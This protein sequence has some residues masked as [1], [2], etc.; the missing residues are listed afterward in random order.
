MTGSG[1]CLIVPV[2]PKGKAGFSPHPPPERWAQQMP[3]L[4][5]YSQRCPLFSVES[6]FVPSQGVLRHIM[7]LASPSPALVSAYQS[8]YPR[9]SGNIQVSVPR[10]LPPIQFGSSSESS[11]EKGF[12][13]TTKSWLKFL[14]PTTLAAG[15]LY[16]NANIV[17][18]LWGL[19]STMSKF[20]ADNTKKTLSSSQRLWN[21]TKSFC[22]TAAATLPGLYFFTK[23][24]HKN[25]LS[26]MGRI[27]NLS[28]HYPTYDRRLADLGT[29]HYVGLA[30]Q[31]SQNLGHW[32][33]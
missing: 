31:R 30:K 13:E 25:L 14:L 28:D 17:K 8:A 29:N 6:V 2:R 26:V 4:R 3:P 16:Q 24:I 22:F 15:A 23:D 12:L 11:E 19:D 20:I 33:F 10:S 9:L 1:I 7:R 32:G 21:N 27:I 18:Y 5:V